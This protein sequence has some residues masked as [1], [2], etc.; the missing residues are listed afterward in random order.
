MSRALTKAFY[1][2][3]DVVAIARELLGKVI[4]TR[5]DGKRTSGIITETEAYAGIS[6]RASHA[7]GGRRT[8]R[9]E[10]MY[11]PG[12]V[13]YVYL[14]YGMH[15]LFNVV[16]SARD[17]PH[18]V[19]IRA[20]KPLDGMEAMQQRRKGLPLRTDGPALATQALGIRTAHN[21]TALS[22]GVISIEDHGIEPDSGR[23]VI[24]PRI[25]V[26]YAGTDAL[27]PYRFRF[28]P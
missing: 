6:D 2:R 4:V 5:F 19:L 20:I 14:C 10:T 17:V 27:L 12:G 1:Q 15:H 24:G 8:A 13:A 25:G 23:I 3:P 7:F 26:D 16:T 28:T 18:A 11:A 21:G 22:R 9:T